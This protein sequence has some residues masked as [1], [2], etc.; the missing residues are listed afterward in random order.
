M[1]RKVVQ[2]PCY[3]FWQ[4]FE[5]IEPLICIFCILCPLST[6]AHRLNRRLKTALSLV[7]KSPLLV[8]I[9]P[10]LQQLVVCWWNSI[11]VDTALWSDAPKVTCPGGFILNPKRAS[12][13][14]SCGCELRLRIILHHGRGRFSLGPS[15]HNS[16]DSGHN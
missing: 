11:K 8:G 1:T 12:S 3:F 15:L 16:N 7:W 2:Y 14:L 9:A 5:S 4:Y 6:E 13:R 10:L